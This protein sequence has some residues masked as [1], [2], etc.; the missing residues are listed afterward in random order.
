[1]SSPTQPTLYSL[2]T[3]ARTHTSDAVDQL[4]SDRSG[5][6]VPL[7]LVRGLEAFTGYARST[8][9]MLTA[10]S[11]DPQSRPQYRAVLQALTAVLEHADTSAT[12]RAPSTSQIQAAGT[13]WGAA[14]D[15]L[16]HNR[17]ILTHV[18][19]ADR[20]ALTNTVLNDLHRTTAALLDQCHDVPDTVVVADRHHHAW[21][22]DLRAI[23]EATTPHAATGSIDE[24]GL[25]ANQRV[26]IEPRTALLT[27]LRD[28]QA[29]ANGVLQDPHVHIEDL[30]NAAII[31]ARTAEF[32]TRLALATERPLHWPATAWEEVQDA[33][34]D[35]RHEWEEIV[36]NFPTHV[37]SRNAPN[38]A[39]AATGR[40]LVLEMARTLTDPPHADTALA[41]I[42]TGIATH[43]VVSQAGVAALDWLVASQ[44]LAVHTR[45]HIQDH[46]TL[47]SIDEYLNARR[48]GL[49]APAS[50]DV[51]D[52][53][54]YRLEGVTATTRHAATQ[55][56]TLPPTPRQGEAYALRTRTETKEHQAAIAS[57]RH[58]VRNTSA[59]YWSLTYH[60]TSAPAQPKP[61]PPAAPAR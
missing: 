43:P 5:S 11:I 19:R 25:L 34:R 44:Q 49:L 4:A 35:A 58:E 9:R 42:K 38:D 60:S 13:A 39:L 21:T 12:P 56:L 33:S 1:M 18:P 30:R 52:R 15:L 37:E 14:A 50:T 23:H 45:H 59:A 47:A 7:T 26:I 54:K 27:Q 10:L 17:H 28:W 24:T 32:T 40:A 55:A 29:L 61:K 8:A 41:L 16:G 31:S 53:T 22:S 48:H 57:A 2:V 51:T 20:E 6:K 46:T 3:Q 36:R